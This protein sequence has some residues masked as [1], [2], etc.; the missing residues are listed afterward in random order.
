MLPLSAAGAQVY[1]GADQEAWLAVDNGVRLRLLKAE[2]SF[3]TP[4]PA[5][6]RRAYS[7]SARLPSDYSGFDLT[8]KSKSNPYCPAGRKTSHVG[9]ICSSSCII[10]QNS[11]EW[12][13]VRI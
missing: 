13:T 7:I 11:H 1:F 2:G 6:R 8:P 12:W 3:R 5:P 4:N 10:L 9:S